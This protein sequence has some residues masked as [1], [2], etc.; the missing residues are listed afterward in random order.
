MTVYSKSNPIGLDK[1]LLKIQEKINEIGWSNISVYGRL[2]VNQR[3]GKK[4]AE[5]Y[6]GANEYKEI[7]LD[8]S[9]NAV[10]GFFIDDTRVGL[11]MIRVPVELVCSCNL[12][13]LYDSTERKDEEALM[14]VHKIIKRITKIVHEKNIR[15]G[16]DNVFRRISIDSF[17]NRDM[18]PWFNFSIEFDV[19]Y[20]NET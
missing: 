3:E 18:H 20:K 2:Y 17:R 15:T 16:L 8:D 11:N 4:I 10:F 14:A 13:K 5:A 1:S 7:L 6:S 19:V 9:K 12:S